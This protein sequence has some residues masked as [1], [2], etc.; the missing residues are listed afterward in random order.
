MIDIDE[1]LNGDV[2]PD[3]EEKINRIDGIVNVRIL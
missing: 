3:I 2:I 1:Q